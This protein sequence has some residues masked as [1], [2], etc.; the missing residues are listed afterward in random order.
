MK[1]KLAAAECNAAEKWHPSEV[2]SGCF[3]SA[4][5]G[6]LIGIAAFHLLGFDWKS[7]YM[8][9]Y[10]EY[11]E[12]KSETLSK[13]RDAWSRGFDAGRDRARESA[14]LHGTGRYEI[15]PTTGEINFKW[16]KACDCKE[17]CKCTK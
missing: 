15:D 4:V 3:A 17:G 9:T 16:L 10:N 11:G 5:A 2:A 12:F 13:E 1:P 14:A 7:E 6:L 8:K